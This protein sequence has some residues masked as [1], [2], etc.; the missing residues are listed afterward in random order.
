MAKTVIHPVDLGVVV[1]PGWEPVIFAKDQPRYRP[2]P[3]LRGRDREGRVITR[4]RPT[5]RERMLVL[6]G[7]DIWLQQLTFRDP[8]QPVLLSIGA[9]AVV[10]AQPRARVA[11]VLVGLACLSLASATAGAQALPTDLC[12]TLRA[13]RA[14]YGSVPTPAELGKIL[15]ATAWT[16]RGDGWGL[17]GKSGGERCP[18]PSGVDVACDILH[19][20]S[21]NLIWDVLVA[22][23]EASTP[24]C[25][26][27]LGAMT[28]PSRPW[29]APVGPGG[30]QPPPP[31][32][33]PPPPSADLKAV[34]AALDALAARLELLRA[35]V[36]V[37]RAAVQTIAVRLDAFAPQIDRAQVES[38]NAAVR[39]L[40]IQ[41]A[42]RTL[43]AQPALVCPAIEWSTVPWPQYDGG[44]VFG[45]R[46]VLRPVKP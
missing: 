23:G 37:L 46:V 28:D 18:A 42:I 13:A 34:Q 26:E 31:P 44:R 3:A 29:V 2:L 40:E 11:T 41:D 1:P 7:A 9:P 4:W 43:A 19:R 35:D 22:A 25:G 8:L 20:R 12:M 27:A 30:E 16:H 39:A 14:Q 10:A 24:N 21:D 15:N 5:W 17:S 38:V 36:A 32:P 45:W 33:L 6:A